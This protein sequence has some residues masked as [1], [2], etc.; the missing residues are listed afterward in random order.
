MKLLQ[1]LLLTSFS[2]IFP[3]SLFA[4]STHSL[5]EF[6][7]KSVE[8]NPEIKEAYFNVDFAEAR[9]DEANAGH[10]GIVEFI[11]LAGVHGNARANGDKLYA[12]DG[13]GNQVPLPQS[14]FLGSGDNTADYQGFGPFAKGTLTAIVP[15]WT[16]GKLDGYVNAA[17][18]GVGVEKAA[19]E[20]KKGEV[21]QRIKEF[22]YGYLLASDALELG[23][24]VG[25]YLDKA[26]KKAHELFDEGNGE[27]SQTDLQRL[28]VGKAELYRQLASAHQG[29]PLA[30]SALAAF[31]GIAPTFK[32]N[33][34]YLKQETFK[35]NSLEELVRVAWQHKPEIKQLAAG[36]TARRNLVKVEESELYPLFF[37]GAQV[38]GGK[39]DARDLS[40]NP[41]L[42][43]DGFGPVSGGPALGLKWNLNFL[44][45]QA[46]IAQARAQYRALQQK[47]ELAKMGLPLQVEEA[48]RKVLEYRDQA[49][50]AEEGMRAARGWM[51]SAS[52]NYEVGIGEPK[53][54][55]EGIGSYAVMKMNLL[56]GR[57][58]Y[59]LALGKLSQLIG[60]EVTGLSY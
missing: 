46:K 59:N 22:F 10:F 14:E 54:L 11:G 37:A 5:S 51:I 26:I 40:H 12:L 2:F 9:L 36:L 43:D 29:L 3:Q 28:D 39:S 7:S 8:K 30:R 25:K 31:S 32:T 56:Q 58:N 45:T 16:W 48:Y 42:N 57:Y 35:I 18:A 44:T 33:P 34:D 27:V 52:N 24:E 13:A 49:K 17:Q 60:Q 1:V 4:D 15:I 41:F 20:I 50:H 19:A 38:Q 53:V 6:I 47:E 21:I 23:D 55:M